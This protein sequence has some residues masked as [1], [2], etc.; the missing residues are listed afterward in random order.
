MGDG[1]FKYSAES[2]LRMGVSTTPPDPK[3]LTTVS[4]TFAAVDACADSPGCARHD[5][6]PFRGSRQGHHAP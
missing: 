2:L 4:A 3:V 5:H 6:R 1:P